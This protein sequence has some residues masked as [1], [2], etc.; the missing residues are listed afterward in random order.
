ML[1]I[2]FMYGVGGVG[3][4]TMTVPLWVSLCVGGEYAVSQSRVWI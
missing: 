4:D 2:G 3:D 1:H